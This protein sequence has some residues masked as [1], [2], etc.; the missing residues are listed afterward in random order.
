MKTIKLTGSQKNICRHALCGGQ[1]TVEDLLSTEAGH[2]RIAHRW[3]NWRDLEP[4]IDDDDAVC[5]VEKPKPK[6]TFWGDH[7]ECEL[8]LFSD[9]SLYY[10]NNAQDE[11]WADAED[12]CV[13]CGLDRLAEEY[14]NSD[15]HRLAQHLGLYE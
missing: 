7:P 15:A 11:V 2:Y 13:E 6:H 3:D 8:L 12:F 1:K 4:A 5:P 14:P 9:G 10:A